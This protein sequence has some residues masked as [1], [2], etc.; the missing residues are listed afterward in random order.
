MVLFRIFG[1]LLQHFNADRLHL[2]IHSS[3]Q[4]INSLTKRT[5]RN[6]YT[7]ITDVAENDVFKTTSRRFA[8]CE[9]DLM[10]DAMTIN[11][12]MIRNRIK[13]LL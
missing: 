7:N 1:Y 5:H 13:A 10:Y 3:S 4:K 9:K 11:N 8:V 6:S 2:F 12:M